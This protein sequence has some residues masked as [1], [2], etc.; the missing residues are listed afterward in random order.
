MG[1]KLDAY[2]ET[3]LILV[4]IWARRGKAKSAQKHK[5]VTDLCKLVWA[6][7]LAGGSARKYL[8]SVAMKRSAFYEG[9]HGL[10]PL[11]RPTA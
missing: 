5:A 4:E 9:S 10:E 3:P 11:Q 1:V 8:Q 6:E 7:K 2:C